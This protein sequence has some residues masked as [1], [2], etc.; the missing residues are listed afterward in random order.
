MSQ[1][2]PTITTLHNLLDYDSGKIA[3]AE[4]Q[5]RTSLPQWIYNANSLQLK[6]VLQKYHDLIE[7][8]IKKMETF[9]DEEKASSFGTINRV[10]AVFIEEA[11]ERLANCTDAEIKDASLLASI[12]V[13]NHFKI[14]CYGT[15]SAF[16]NALGM[17]KIAAAFHEA[18][19]NEKQIDERLSQLAE[20]EV[21][22]KAKA[23]IVLPG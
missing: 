9:I 22:I 17:K 7:Q 20:H 18:E 10:M 11:N 6:T 2:N 16:S 12:Q 15:A 1:N 14:S 4:I 3:S 8:H 13:I 23:P 21:N 5:L 19:M